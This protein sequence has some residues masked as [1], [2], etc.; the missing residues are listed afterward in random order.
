MK[1]PILIEC[2]FGEE[3][4]WNLFVEEWDEI[5]KA[6][7]N[8][9]PRRMSRIE[10]LEKIT[11][12]HFAYLSFLYGTSLK[13]IIKNMTNEIMFKNIFIDTE[14]MFIDINAKRMFIKK[15]P[16][17]LCYVFST[18]TIF[19]KIDMKPIPYNNIWKILPKK[20]Y[21]YYKKPKK[22]NKITQKSKTH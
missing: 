17:N 15:E 8:L 16:H 22:L 18:K 5:R 4:I 3:E 9:S 20:I 13:Y 11:I 7:Y 1:E 19:L 21:N 10:F 12:R 14:R 6:Q 2:Y